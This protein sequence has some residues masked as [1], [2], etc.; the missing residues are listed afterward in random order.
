[1]RRRGEVHRECTQVD[2]PTKGIAALRTCQSVKGRENRNS[3]KSEITVTGMC[4]IMGLH[5][6]VT[7]RSAVHDIK[8]SM[9]LEG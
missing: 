8:S 7:N 2:V 6:Q 1:M 3:L 9:G 4:R 5:P